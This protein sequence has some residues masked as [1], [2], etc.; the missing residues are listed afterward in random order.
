LGAR[1]GGSSS[2]ESKGREE[3]Q[4]ITLKKLA[5]IVK[6]FQVNFS[7]RLYAVYHKNKVR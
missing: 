7:T 1:K 2:E 5:V 6:P 4:E 3:V